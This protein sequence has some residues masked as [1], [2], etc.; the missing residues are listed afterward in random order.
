MTKVLIL[1][2]A[3]DVIHID[4]G[5]MPIALAITCITASLAFPS[6][7]GAV[8]ETLITHLPKRSSVMTVTCAFEDLG[9]TFTTSRMPSLVC[10]YSFW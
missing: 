1:E 10:S 9:V 7:G 6:L 4:D 3:P 8:T 5:G 2:L